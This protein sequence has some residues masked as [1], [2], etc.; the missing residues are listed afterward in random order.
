MPALFFLLS[1]Q[2][3]GTNIYLCLMSEKV[4]IAM[5]EDSPPKG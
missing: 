2:W 1:T 5:R 4:K 3:Q